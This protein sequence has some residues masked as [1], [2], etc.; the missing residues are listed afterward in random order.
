MKKFLAG[1][2]IA[3]FAA[4]PIAFAQNGA[5]GDDQLQSGGAAGTDNA[6]VYTYAALAGVSVAALVGAAFAVSD[7][8]DK[9]VNLGGTGGTS[10]TTGTGGTGGTTG[11]G[12]ASGTS[13]TSGT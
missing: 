9:N 8:D 5:S 7:N 12:G 3:M 11:T 2:S 13:G 6:Q 10:G 4:S 1:I